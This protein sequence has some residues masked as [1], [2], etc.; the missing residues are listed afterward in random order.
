M[1]GHGTKL[2]RKSEDA[3]AALLTHRN[4]EEAAQTCGISGKTLLRWLKLP[5]FKSAYLA[6]RREVVS[7]ANA[8]LQ[9]A[10][11]AAVST[12][13]KIMIDPTVPASSR[14]RA[15]DRI[16]DHAKY[17]IELE[18]IEMRVSA[19]EAGQQANGPGPGS[20]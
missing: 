15:A 2:G 4:V 3:I 6:A 10:S 8:R 16:L 5:E 20:S 17:A 14:V 19:L 7:Q 9:Q 13:C 1:K 11:G 12:L 18:D